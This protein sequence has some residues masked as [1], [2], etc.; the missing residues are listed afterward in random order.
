MTRNVMFVFAALLLI[1]FAQSAQAQIFSS[2]LDDATGWA[3][4]ADEDTEY[5][6]GF[7]YSPFG[8]PAAP[9][10]SGTTGLRMAANMVEPGAAAAISAYP[11]D[12][13]LTGQ[14]RV[15]VD[16]WLNYNTSGGTS[17]GGSPVR[18]SDQLPRPPGRP[19]PTSR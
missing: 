5:Q 9:N 7:D 2:N 11:T 18:R 10:G 19:A 4:V 8:I 15:E 12:L 14:Y 3:V 16:M 1:S 17:P 13:N 6:F